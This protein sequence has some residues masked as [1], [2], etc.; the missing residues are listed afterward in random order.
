MAEDVFGF[1]G[2]CAPGLSGRGV[3]GCDLLTHIGIP[4]RDPSGVGTCLM[5]VRSTDPCPICI[6]HCS[7]SKIAGMLMRYGNVQFQLCEMNNCITSGFDGSRRV[8]PVVPRTFSE[9]TGASEFIA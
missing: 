9:H 8:Q 5:T 1:V 2:D 4:A 7:D 6:S 3:L